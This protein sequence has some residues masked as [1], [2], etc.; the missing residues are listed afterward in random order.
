MSPAPPNLRRTSPGLTR[1]AARAEAIWS[2]A[3]PKTG[4]PSGRPVSRAASA[5]TAP[6]QRVGVMHGRERFARDMRQ[7]DEIVVDLVVAEIDEPGL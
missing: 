2:A 6:K 5:L 7:G 4:R 3:P 1:P